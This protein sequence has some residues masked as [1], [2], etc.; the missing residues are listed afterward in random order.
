MRNV[1]GLPTW[2]SGGA[3]LL[4]GQLRTLRAFKLL[5]AG[6]AGSLVARIAGG[7]VVIGRGNITA[8]CRGYAAWMCRIC[9]RRAGANGLADGSARNGAGSW[10][11]AAATCRGR[12]AIAS[13]RQRGIRRRRR[14]RLGSHR[15][16]RRKQCWTTGRCCGELTL[17]RRL[18]RSGRDLNAKRTQWRGRRNHLVVAQSG[19][20][21]AHRLPQGVCAGGRIGSDRSRGRSAMRSGLGGVPPAIGASLARSG[22]P[23]VPAGGIDGSEAPSLVNAVAAAVGA[24]GRWLAALRWAIAISPRPTTVPRTAMRTRMRFMRMTTKRGV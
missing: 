13:R 8:A 19:E 5:A 18:G 22:L 21:I 11:S 4:N 16:G 12:I 10:P 20:R 6:L 24:S 15:A 3:D 17:G 1:A 23:D 14:R 7:L 9:C 2:I